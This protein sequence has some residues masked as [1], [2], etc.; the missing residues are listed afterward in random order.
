MTGAL[1][2]VFLDVGGPIYDDENFVAAVLGALDA[3][4]AADGVG[5]VDRAAF[6][7]IYDE[8]RSAQ[9]GSL[10]GALASAFLG[11]RSRR[12]ELHAETRRRWVHPAGT[13]YPD[14]LPFLRALDGRV[15]VGILANQEAAVIAALERDGVAPYID[16]W[17][18]S[19]VVGHE[20]PSP[21]LFEW[22]LA[23]A[24]VTADEAVHI[25]NRLDTDV[26]PA[27]ALGLG[28]VWVLRGEAPPVP[29]AAQLAE[30]DLAVPGLDGLAPALFALQA[31]RA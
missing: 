31:G 25:G 26:R 30:P 5:P 19:A 1:R 4:R 2:A 13:L 27:A 3:L 6:R 9:G 24:G 21:E 22:A 12:A 23:E 7:T 16:V 8:V 18:V 15:R 20:K 17:G 28:T 14:V 10:R 11:S 29:T